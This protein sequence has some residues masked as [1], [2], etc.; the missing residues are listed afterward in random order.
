MLKRAWWLLLLSFIVPGSAQLLAGNRKLARVALVATGLLWSIVVLLVLIALP[1]EGQWLAAI[2]TQG[3]FLTGVTFG[4]VGYAILYGLIA[5]D[6]L[7]L[8][9]VGRMV[10][11]DKW[12]ATVVLLALETSAECGSLA[13]LEG[14]ALLG[15]V[16]LDEGERHAGEH[17][18]ALE[19]IDVVHLEHRVFVA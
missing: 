10:P 7:R 19:F 13:L 15:E 4:L 8:M 17:Q 5:L 18:R 12:I 3:W 2:A 16:L 14:E 9:Q 6:T 1:F 11:R